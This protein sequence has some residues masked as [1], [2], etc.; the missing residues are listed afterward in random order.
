MF[1]NYLIGT[2]A[3]RDAAN[4]QAQL[5]KTVTSVPASIEKTVY[6]DSLL[7]QVG[8]LM[9]TAQDQNDIVSYGSYVYT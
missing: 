8:S 9:W 3:D 1:F 4:L 7:P 2:F 6:F 5:C